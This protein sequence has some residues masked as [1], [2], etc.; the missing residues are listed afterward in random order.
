MVAYPEVLTQ[1]VYTDRAWMGMIALSLL[2]HV[3]LFSGV[4]L[5]PELEFTRP[6]IPSAVEVDLVSLPQGA[7]QVQPGVVAPRIEPKPPPV[8]RI[9]VTEVTKPER[10][11]PEDEPVSMKGPPLKEAVSLAPQQ[12][13]VK[14]SLKKKTYNVSKVI[15]Q[16]IAKIQQE[17]PGSR[18][19]PVLE[20]IDQLK[21]EV[22][23][24]AGV[25]ASG[26][27]AVRGQISQ[28]DLELLDIYHAEIWDEIQKNWAYAQEMAGGQTNLEAVIIVKIMRDGEIRDI[29]FEKRSGNSYFDD[30]AYKAVKKSNPLPPLPEGF[31]K[32]FHEVGFR[33]NPSEWNRHP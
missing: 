8:E 4:V 20:A 32:P 23:G 1:G 26:G 9:K 31:L 29:W 3:L 13:Q 28:R 30:S 14:K 7:P 5:L 12:L 27:G 17:A 2:C 15:S 19:R 33:F 21:K 11:E 22:E 25:V 10:A 24:E 16:A 6:L 18:P